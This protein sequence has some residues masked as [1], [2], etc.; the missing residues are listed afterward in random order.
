[1]KAVSALVGALAF[2]LCLAAHAQNP[3]PPAGALETAAAAES[4]DLASIMA[5]QQERHTKLWFAGRAGNWPLA[6]YEL[7][8]LGDGFDQVN[9][10]FGGD[11]VDKVVGGP[12]KAL[13]KLIAEKNQAGFAAAFDALTAGC[14]NCHHMLDHAFILIQRPTLQP[15]SDQSFAPQK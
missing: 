3:S 7:D 15:Y 13:E 1:M 10:L 8:A 4:G 6:S 11:M 5:Q 9:N 14:N 2:S 12:M